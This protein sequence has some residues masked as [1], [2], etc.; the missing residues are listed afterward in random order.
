M[1]MNSPKKNHV[2]I[3]LVAV[4]HVLKVPTTGELKIELL[5]RCLWQPSSDIYY[6][7]ECYPYSFFFLLAK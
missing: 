7:A 3:A 6:L 4:K 1:Y 5:T 2:L